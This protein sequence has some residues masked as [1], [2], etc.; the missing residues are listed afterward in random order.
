MKVVYSE[1]YFYSKVELCM[2]SHGT[3]F[4]TNQNIY[5]LSFFSSLPPVAARTGPKL[6]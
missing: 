6:L 2:V 4:Q 3:E 1:F 5:S